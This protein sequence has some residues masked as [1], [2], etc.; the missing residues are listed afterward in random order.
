VKRARGPATAEESGALLE[1][2]VYTLLRTY[3]AERELGDELAH[4]APAESS[5]V[6]VDFLVRRGPDLC[7]LEV[8]AAR[9]FQ[10]HQLAGL[11]AVAGLPELRRRVLIYRGDRALRTEDGIDVWPVSAFLEALSAGGLWP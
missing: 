2:W 7:A 1:G 3:M 8:K 11:R 10:R 4:W 6:E 5:G 9:R